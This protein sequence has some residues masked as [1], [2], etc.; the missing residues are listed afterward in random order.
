MISNRS[1]TI[2]ACCKQSLEFC[3]NG[4]RDFILTTTSKKKK[5]LFLFV[6]LKFKIDL[7]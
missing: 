1:D 7:S 5:T 2:Q 4:A 3:S 6:K